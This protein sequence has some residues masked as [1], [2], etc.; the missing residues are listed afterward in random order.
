MGG[1]ASSLLATLRTPECVVGHH[2]NIVL[3]II[4]LPLFSLHTITNQRGTAPSIYLPWSYLDLS[5]HYRNQPRHHRHPTHHLTTMPALFTAALVSLFQQGHVVP[6]VGVAAR[7]PPLP[8]RPEAARAAGGVVS[9]AILVLTV[10]LRVTPPSAPFWVRRENIDEAG[11]TAVDNIAKRSQRVS[12]A[13][14]CAL[15]NAYR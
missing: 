10:A 5:R 11:G 8:L 6:L 3:P 9:E 14:D 7:K 1:G 15:I 2:K 4:C 13:E 12:R